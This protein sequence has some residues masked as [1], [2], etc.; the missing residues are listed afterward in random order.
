LCGALAGGACSGPT[1]AGGGG[2]RV[3]Q[4]ASRQ[5]RNN[6]AGMR[7]LQRPPTPLSLQIMALRN[8]TRRWGAIAQ[9]F[10]WVIVALIIAQ[11]TLAEM[12]DDLPNGMRKLKLLASHKSVGITILSLVILRLA[13]R[14]LNEHP[15]LPENL[16]RYE[17]ALARFTHVALYVLLFAMPLSG[18]TMSSA[19]GFPVSWF[20]FFQLPDLV[21]KSRPLYDALLT[22][23]HS[24]A[25]VLFVVIGLHVAGALKHH[26]V[27]KDDV[28]RRMLPFTRT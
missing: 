5:A 12:A 3:G 16:K 23:H 21:P 28:L 13:W 10:H 7:I 15:P 4:A 18:W 1:S 6:V 8:T 27:H 24:L 20:G 9:T 19:R 22:I 25:W 26:F 11:V 17:Q 14:W 2:G